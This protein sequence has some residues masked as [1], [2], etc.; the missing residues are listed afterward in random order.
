MPR[1]TF[2]SLDFPTFPFV[3]F[4]KYLH[5]LINKINISGYDEGGREITERRKNDNDCKHPKTA[6]GA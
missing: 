3:Y 4:I 2:Y 1:T 5:I 6:D